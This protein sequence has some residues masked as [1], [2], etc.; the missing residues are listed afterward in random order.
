MNQ[1][2]KQAR[3]GAAADPADNGSP[4]EL[5][6]LTAML[7]TL[8]EAFTGP[9]DAFATPVTK[10]AAQDLLTALIG[11]DG[12]DKEGLWPNLTQLL[13]V[14]R[15]FFI[16]AGKPPGK[17]AVAIPAN[18]FVP[19]LSLPAGI[20]GVR[21]P[22]VGPFILVPVRTEP[23]PTRQE[24]DKELGKLLD[25]V[26]IEQAA[27]EASRKNLKDG[28][29]EPGKVF[30]EL[31]ERVRQAVPG[32]R[33]QVGK[34]SQ[35]TRRYFD[36]NPNARG[37]EDVPNHFARA[38]GQLQYAHAHPEAPFPPPVSKGENNQ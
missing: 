7:A 37:R 1:S 22:A 33:R 29:I 10:K 34:V 30:Q 19:N 16:P 12:N 11:A 31:V 9:L 32:L 17:L 23:V 20:G 28:T 2:K 38:E 27:A 21:G 24:I 25:T 35:Q 5:E 8:T 26:G 18:Q 36:A 14:I 4:T 15:G 6:R 3:A 13:D